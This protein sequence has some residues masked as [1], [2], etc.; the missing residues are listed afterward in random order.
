MNNTLFPAVVIQRFFTSFGYF[1]SEI[2]FL[3]FCESMIF[4]H[5]SFC[6]NSCFAT[7]NYTRYS[8]I[9]SV[10]VQLNWCSVFFRFLQIEFAQRRFIIDSQRKL[11]LGTLRW[12]TVTGLPAALWVSL[13]D[14]RRHTTNKRK[15][16]DK[17][18]TWMFFNLTKSN[19]IAC[20]PANRTWYV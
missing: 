14:F 1:S 10:D 3:E 12:T 4:P 19:C 16:V 2:P 9:L 18:R 6:M 8:S 7:R 5:W 17:P 15:H 11:P 20:S 13:S